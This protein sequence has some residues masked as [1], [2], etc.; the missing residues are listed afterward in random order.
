[1]GTPDA[2]DMDTSAQ[3]GSIQ[4][5]GAHEIR[6]RLRLATRQRIYQIVSRPDFPEPV[7]KLANG[8]VWL[9]DDV[10]EWIKKHRRSL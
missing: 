7:A 6:V 8:R 9:I 3:I 1:M 2:T 4:L 10:E 5:V